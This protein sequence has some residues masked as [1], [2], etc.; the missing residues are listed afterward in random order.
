MA[1]AALVRAAEELI[2]ERGWYGASASEVVRASGQRNNSAI[3]YH[4][5]SWEGLLDAVWA[6]HADPINADRRARL[7]AA[8]AGESL[9]LRELLAIY[10]EPIVAEIRRNVPSY[11]ARFNEQWL[12]RVPLDVFARPPG[13]P[14]DHNPRPQTVTLLTTVFQQIVAQLTHLPSEARTHRVA[15]VARFV[16]TALAAWER[17][18]TGGA[19]RPLEEL[20]EELID[21]SLALLQ[22]P[23]GQRPTPFTP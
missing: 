22:A 10:V 8:Q 7:E 3:G 5:G 18:A 11:W 1:K 21:L 2:A 6:C 14:V 4:F 15:L 13:S 12:T 19:A 17:D 23:K 16:I 9:G 20:S